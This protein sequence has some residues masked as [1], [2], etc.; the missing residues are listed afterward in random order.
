MKSLKFPRLSLG[1]LLIGLPL[2]HLGVVS[3]FV[4]A[5]TLGF[6][7]NIAGFTSPDMLFSTS[8][9]DLAPIYFIGIGLPATITLTR[10][11][12]GKPNR[13]AEVAKISDPESRA[14][15]MD[16]LVRT[17]KLLVIAIWVF[18]LIITF[19]SLIRRYYFG[20]LISILAVGAAWLPVAGIWIINLSKRLD[21]DDFTYE[22]LFI[23]ATLIAWVL[24]VGVDRG[25]LDRALTFAEAKERYVRCGDKA[26]LRVFGE[27]FLAVD[28]HN[29]QLFIDRDCVAKFV[30]PTRN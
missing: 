9:R 7:G 12:K 30:V 21:L 8:I 13:E 25:N 3:L 15:A 26:V 29:R 28:S 11:S 23:G 27:L 2:V 1:Q 4:A 20:E 6:G 5:Y 10:Y 22:V 14:R 17:R 24:I 18:A 19:A 16:D